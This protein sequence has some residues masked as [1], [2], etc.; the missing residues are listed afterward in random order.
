MKHLKLCIWCKKNPVKSP[1]SLFC[2]TKCSAQKRSWD[3]KQKREKN[4]DCPWS[5]ERLPEE[6]T[7]NS[8]SGG[9]NNEYEYPIDK[10]LLLED[11][12]KEY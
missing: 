7:K 4:F 6:A 1:T 10:V 3:L 5:S 12:D 2:S 8:Y 11:D 9:F